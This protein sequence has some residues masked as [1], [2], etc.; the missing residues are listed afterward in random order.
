MG[1]GARVREGEMRLTVRALR[2][3]VESTVAGDGEWVVQ[4]AGRS[5]DGLMK[6]GE[7][8]ILFA[9]RDDAAEAADAW[10]VSSNVEMGF[11]EP[12]RVGAA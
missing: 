10:N 2:R 3:V 12:I 8:P 7:E 5:Y 1:V 6:R 9:S 4:I 11:A